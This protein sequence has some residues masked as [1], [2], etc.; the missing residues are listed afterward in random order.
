MIKR[1]VFNN[2]FLLL[3]LYFLIIIKLVSCES[4]NDNSKRNS[5]SDA[6]DT[7]QNEIRNESFINTPFLVEG[8]DQIGNK[9]KGKI[10]FKNDNGAGY[11]WN[12]SIDKIYIDAKRSI[13]G[14]F[15]AIDNG[16]NHYDLLQVVKT[17][18]VW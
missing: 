11:L 14:G 5:E 4:K 18:D 10:Y 17:S 1:I 9:Y 7:V 3:F 16:G 12:D 15:E 13:D 2:T 8:N 6:I